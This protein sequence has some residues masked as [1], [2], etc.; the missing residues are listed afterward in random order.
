[1]SIDSPPPDRESGS[2]QPRQLGIAAVVVLL[3]FGVAFGVGKAASGSDDSAGGGQKAKALD[4]SDA[5]LSAAV[6]SGGDLPALKARK[7]AKKESS[8]SSDSS[9]AGSTGGGGSGGTTQPPASTPT[10]PTS[11]GGSATGGGGGG[12]GGDEPVT[13][14]GGTD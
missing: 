12:G 14:G 10:P 6:Q 2:V 7:K 13:S 5:K 1:M 3:V 11:G 9:S 8:S 4:L